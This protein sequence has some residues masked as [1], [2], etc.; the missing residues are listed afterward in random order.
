[1]A[2]RRHGSLTAFWNAAAVSATN[3]SAAVEIGRNVGD[4]AIY[5]T[6]SAAAT[7]Y[8]QVG[9]SGSDPGG[10]QDDTTPT[11]WHAVCYAS[12][13]PLVLTTAAAPLLSVA[14]IIPDFEAGWLRLYCLSPAGPTTVTAGYEVSSA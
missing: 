10:I 11:V 7:F 14:T 3:T 13:N 5:L 9:H 8:L 12:A 6:T 1:M 4:L 2:T